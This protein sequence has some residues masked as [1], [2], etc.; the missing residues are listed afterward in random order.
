[1]SLFDDWMLTIA[2]FRL[3]YYNIERQIQSIMV[4]YVVHLC[5]GIYGS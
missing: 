4:C 2:P 3:D 1:M 5:T